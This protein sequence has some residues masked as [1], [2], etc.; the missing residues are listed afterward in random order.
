MEKIRRPTYN[1]FASIVAMNSLFQKYTDRAVHHLMPQSIAEDTYMEQAMD[2]ETPE[3]WNSMYN[4]MREEMMENINKS[5]VSFGT[6]PS[7][8]CGKKYCYALMNLIWIF[9]LQI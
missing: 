3:D 5:S 9:F 1:S 4:Q 6:R 2:A 7:V 8:E